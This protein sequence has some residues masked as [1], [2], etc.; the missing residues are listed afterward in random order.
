MVHVCVVPGCSNRSSRETNLS[1]YHLPLKNKKLLKVW[2]HKIRR[3]NLPLNT[4]SHVCSIHFEN[5]RGRRLRPDEYPIAHLP[6]VSATQGRKRKS[7]TKRTQ[8]MQVDHS[9]DCHDSSGHDSDDELEPKTNEVEVQTMESSTNLLLLQNQIAE[10]K[11]K[12]DVSQ[13][14]L[15]NI[16]NNSQKVQYYTGFSNYVTFEIFYQSLGPSVNCLN[17]WGSEIIGEA[18]SARGRNRSLPPME[19]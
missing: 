12:L 9:E 3:N 14:R 13:F 5:A 18:K 6:L 17:Y 2:V 11:S 7:P 16:A 19:E 10:L 15:S 8:F 4:N 1:Y